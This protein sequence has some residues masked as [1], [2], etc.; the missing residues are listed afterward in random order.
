MPGVRQWKQTYGIELYAYSRCPE[1]PY[2]MKKCEVLLAAMTEY[3]ASPG[4]Y[5]AIFSMIASAI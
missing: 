1:N 3:P 2:F 4:G 5:H